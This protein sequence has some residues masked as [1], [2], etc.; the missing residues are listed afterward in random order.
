[1]STLDLNS[2]TQQHCEILKLLQDG[3]KRNTEI[4]SELG[5]PL[6]T[7]FERVRRMVKMGLITSEIVTIVESGKT[8]LRPR[9]STITPLG[10]K[11]LEKYLGGYPFKRMTKHGPDK[12]NNRD[13]EKAPRWTH[14]IIYEDVKVRPETPRFIPHAASMPWRGKESL[15][16]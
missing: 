15:A 2:I 4:E 3:P 12:W 7:V 16:E 1:M 11:I 10:R 5:Y 9:V 6:K 8:P 14:G 13:P